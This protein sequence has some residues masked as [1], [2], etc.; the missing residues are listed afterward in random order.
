M[1]TGLAHL[2][3]ILGAGGT[4]VVLAGAQ[5]M[6]RRLKTLSNGAARNVRNIG[7]CLEKVHGEMTE[8]GEMMK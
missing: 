3:R 6:P 5:I 4:V 8:A 7:E 2:R 1:T